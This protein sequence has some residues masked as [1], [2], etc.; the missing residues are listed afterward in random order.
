MLDDDFEIV[1]TPDG[2]IY[3]NQGLLEC[4]P[5][6]SVKKAEKYIAKQIAPKPKDKTLKIYNS[7]GQLLF[8][9]TR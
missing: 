7:K 6:G 9:A 4:G 5:F 1:E 8:D 3:V 2:D